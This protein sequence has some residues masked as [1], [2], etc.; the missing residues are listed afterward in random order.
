MD[1]FLQLALQTNRYKKVPLSGDGSLRS[2]TRIQWSN[3]SGILVYSSDRVQHKLFLIRQQE[4]VNSQIR[5]PGLKFSKENSP[6]L[7]IEDLGDTTLEKLVLDKDPDVLSYYRQAIDQVFTLQKKA[8]VLSWDLQ[9]LKLFLKEMLWT[10][11]YLIDKFLNSKV[12][13]PLLKDCVKEWENMCETL[14]SFPYLPSHRD[15]HSRNIMI[16]NHKTYMIDF[17]DAKRFP[18]FYDLVSLLYDPYSRLSDSRRKELLDYSLS[19]NSF[20]KQ[21]KSHEFEITLIQRLFKAC[22]NFAGFYI[23]KKKD[24]HLKYILPAVRDIEL[25]LSKIKIYPNFHRL[26]Q[27]LKGEISRCL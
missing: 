12:K 19:H 2:Y 5:V 22:G 21:D 26:I 24:T 3:Q 27:S 13:S 9:D 8:K 4:L 1:A 6:Y 17:Q 16:K 25:M 10:K 20:L 7:F 15:Y 14:S 11:K 18:R 23:L